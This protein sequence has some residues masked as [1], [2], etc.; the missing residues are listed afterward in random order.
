MPLPD[1][2]KK[3]QVEDGDDEPNAME[4]LRMWTCTSNHRWISSAVIA[5]GDGCPRCRSTVL[6]GGP[7]LVVA[8]F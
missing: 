6:V 7:A 5:F 4:D 2:E 8:P 3:Q 1:A